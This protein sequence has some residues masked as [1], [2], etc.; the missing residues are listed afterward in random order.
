M[1]RLP[2]KFGR[3]GILLAVVGGRGKV[4]YMGHQEKLEFIVQE[5]L[6]ID[7]K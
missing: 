1:V 3:M 6:A 5:I 4:D 7:V 2:S